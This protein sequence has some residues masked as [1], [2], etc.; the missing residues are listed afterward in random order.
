[1]KKGKK[2]ADVVIFLLLIFIA[3]VILYP[4]V[5]MV[6][7]SFKPK[8]HVYLGGLLPQVWDF[9]S[10][11]QIW[12]EIPMVRGF[13][14]TSLYSVPPVLIG[15]LVSGA[16]AFAFAKVRF[17]GRDTLFLILL[18]GLMI[19]FPAIMVPQFVLFSEANLLNGPW[20]MILPKLFGNISMVFFVRQIISSWP[21]SLTDAAKIDGCNYWQMYWKIVL[22]NIRY[23]LYAHGVL[24]FIAAWNDYLGPTLFIQNPIWE[25]VTVMIAKYNAQYEINNHIPRIM[26]G[27]V[28]LITPVLIIYG[29]FQK[30]IVESFVFSGIKG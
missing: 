8:M 18:I 23:A 4:F 15:T 14:N 25:P 19:P 21:D 13:L 9:S 20:T 6:L 7:T 12:N 22:P 16:A 27:S 29:I 24:W 3:I 30:Y 5:W 28:L 11:L 17:K 26:A 10:Y 2:I 1:M